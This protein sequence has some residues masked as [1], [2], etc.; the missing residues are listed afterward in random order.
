MWE[1][2]ERKVGENYNHLWTVLAWP[3]PYCKHAIP[4]VQSRV[5]FLPLSLL[6]DLICLIK[7]VFPVPAWPV[8]TILWP[9]DA[10][11]RAKRDIFTTT[12]CHIQTTLICLQTDHAYHLAYFLCR[13]QPI[14]MQLTNLHHLVRDTNP[15]FYVNGGRGHKL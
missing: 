5:T 9:P 10:R 14:R 4:V 6:S 12:A 1:I 15:C 8:M 3:S 2:L 7:C 11:S 13:P